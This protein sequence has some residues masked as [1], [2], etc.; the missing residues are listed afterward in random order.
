MQIRGG[1]ALPFAVL[2]A[3]SEAFTYADKAPSVCQAG[4]ASL[5]PESEVAHCNFQNVSLESN[6]FLPFRNPCL[7]PICLLY[8]VT[9]PQSSPRAAARALIE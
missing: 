7:G 6:L 1:Q 4:H 8:A 2:E 3:G 9:D 5:A